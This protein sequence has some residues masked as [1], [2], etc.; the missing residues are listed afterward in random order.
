MIVNCC[1][2]P[3]DGFWN[4]NDQNRDTVEAVLREDLRVFV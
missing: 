3:T 2:L 4:T 1:K